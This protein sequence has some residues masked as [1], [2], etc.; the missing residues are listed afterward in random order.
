MAFMNPGGVGPACSLQPDQRRRA[1][2][3]G[4]LRRG[5]QR[6]AV[7]E[8]AGRRW[9]C[10]GSAPLRRAGAAVQQPVGAGSK[11]GRCCRRR[12]STYHWTTVGWS[13]TSS[14]ARSRSTAWATFVSKS[15]ELSRA[16][17]EHRTSPPTVGDGFTTF[18]SCTDALGGEI[19]LDAFVTG[20]PP[21]SFG[22]RASTRSPHSVTRDRHPQVTPDPVRLRDA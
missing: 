8:H 13:R 3:A 10:T 6:P 17:T 5:V 4:H 14:T 22:A 15:G 1:A 2:R 20:A 18:K 21:G 7:R 12:T 9:T 19:D 16:L 11:P